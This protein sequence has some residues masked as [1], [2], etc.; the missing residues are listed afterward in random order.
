MFTIIKLKVKKKIVE[1]VR[2]DAS[3]LYEQ[4]EV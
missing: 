3:C 1:N 2:C 4:K